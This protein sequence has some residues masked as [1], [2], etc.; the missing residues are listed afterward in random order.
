MQTIGVVRMDS[1]RRQARRG[2]V[3]GVPSE[4]RRM[5]HSGSS[6]VTG[7]LCV[8]WLRHEPSH[9]M[10]MPGASG[11]SRRPPDWRACVSTDL[12]CPRWWYNRRRKDDEAVAKIYPPHVLCGLAYLVSWGAYLK[13]ACQRAQIR[14]A[15]IAVLPT[16]F[17]DLFSTN[18]QT[19]RARESN[20]MP[21]SVLVRTIQQVCSARPRIGSKLTGPSTPDLPR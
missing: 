16:V 1:K 12:S 14:V 18:V 17:Q 10:W 11:T 21:L 6:R 8:C 13:H 19:L 7:V 3:T 15:F 20:S 5:L 4:D 2:S 9:N